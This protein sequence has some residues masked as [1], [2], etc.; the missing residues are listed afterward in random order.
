MTTPYDDRLAALQRAG[1]LASVSAAVA[2]AGDPVWHGSLVADPATPDLGPAT[3]YR[4]GSITKTLTAVLVLQLRD[5]GRIDLADP[6]GRFV[7]RTGYAEATLRDLLAHTAGLQSEPAGSWWERSPGVGIDALLAANDGAGRVAGA[8]EYFHYSNLGFALLGEVVARLH[9][10]PWWEV[11]RARLLDPL[12]MGATTYLPPEDHAPG[13]SVDHFAHTLSPEPL[14][15]TGAMAPAGQL[16][17]TPADLL[18]WADFLVTGHPGVLSA[19]TLAEMATPT[20]L[21]G[22]YGLGLR[23]LAVEGRTLVGHTGSM[24]GFQ[25]SLFADRASRDAVAVLA[26]ATTGLDTDAAPGVLLGLTPAP[27]GGAPWR[28]SAVPV[29]DP[30]AAVL[31]VWFWGNTAFGFEWTGGELVVRDLRSGEVEDRFGLRPG[32]DAFTGTEGYHRGET[33]RA[34]RRPGGEVSHLECATFVWTRTPYDPRAPI[35]GGLA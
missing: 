32:G 16:W 3:S 5:E 12:G 8:G 26:N 25:A 29:P 13:R 28:P 22:D 9:E 27:A 19:A 2:R 4:I 24:P 30:V 11:V 17:S 18:R 6:V 15:D 10:A 23:V 35:P 34:V 7:P 20:V 14:T 21:G 33:L 31:G 1:R